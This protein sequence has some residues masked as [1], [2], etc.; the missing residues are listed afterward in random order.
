V[1]SVFN[2]GNKFSPTAG[3]FKDKSEFNKR[4]NRPS[5]HLH[6]FSN[7]SKNLAKPSGKEDF[8]PATV[9]HSAKI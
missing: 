3:W 1:N 7:I 5:S 8:F 9:S 4:G 6:P 2:I